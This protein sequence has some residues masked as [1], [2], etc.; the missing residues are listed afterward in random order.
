[1]LWPQEHTIPILLSSFSVTSKAI[2]MG[3]MI[4]G[5]MD[6]N[7]AGLHHLEDSAKWWVK[8]SAPRT[9]GIKIPK[10]AMP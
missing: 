2:R 3:A 4:V 10:S 1:M 6:Q 7:T 8:N 5:N 9:P